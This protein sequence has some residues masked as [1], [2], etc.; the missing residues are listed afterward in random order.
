[1]R[2]SC[3]DAMSNNVIS[4][5]YL[6]SAQFAK[7]YS[8]IFRRSINPLRSRFI[9]QM[10]I[11]CTPIGDIEFD[12]FCRHELIPILNPSKDGWYNSHNEYFTL[13]FLQTQLDQQIKEYS[14][15]SLR[16]FLSQIGN[17]KLELSRLKEIIN[18]NYQGVWFEESPIHHAV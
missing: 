7:E 12:V 1:M 9:P 6:S 2:K 15:I 13:K 17:P 14:I 18:N 10:T 11:G 3:I 8:A 16:N 4:E 5:A